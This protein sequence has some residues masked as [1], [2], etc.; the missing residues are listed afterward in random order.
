VCFGNGK[1]FHCVVSCRKIQSVV[2]ICRSE[3]RFDGA[4]DRLNDLRISARCEMAHA[5]TI[6]QV[7]PALLAGTDQ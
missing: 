6:D 3:Q 4:S 1:R 7:Y 2:E 5:I